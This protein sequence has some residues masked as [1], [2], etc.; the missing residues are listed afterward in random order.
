MEHMPLLKKMCWFH[1]EFTKLYM[2]LCCLFNRKAGDGFNEVAQDVKEESSKEVP[3]HE[4]PVQQPLLD[5]GVSILAD[6]ESDEIDNLLSSSL[7]LNQSKSDIHKAHHDPADR[8]V[9]G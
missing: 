9:S 4:S 3:H 2:I 8:K 5:E 6:N 7:E 1:S